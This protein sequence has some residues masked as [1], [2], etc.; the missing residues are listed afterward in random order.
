MK[1][2]VFML[3]CTVLLRSSALGQCPATLTSAKAENPSRLVSTELGKSIENESVDEYVPLNNIPFFPGGKP[4]LDAYFLDPDLYPYS[5]RTTGI[6][7]VVEVSFRVQ[8]T[9]FLTNIR[10]VKSQGPLLDKAALRAVVQMPRWY[11]AH[12]AGMAVSC[13]MSLAIRFEGD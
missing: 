10:V 6:E 11:P 7:G 5:A 12:Q 8:P 13:P 1:R 9:G 3:V 4:A 2:N